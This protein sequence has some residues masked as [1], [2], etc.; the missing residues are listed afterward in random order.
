MNNERV[1]SAYRGKKLDYYYALPDS[2]SF[3]ESQ[4]IA[5]EEDVK[6]KTAEKWIY[7]FRN[8]GFLLNPVKGQFHKV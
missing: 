4:Q 7:A 1:E 2:F 6:I 5:A 3:K 8:N